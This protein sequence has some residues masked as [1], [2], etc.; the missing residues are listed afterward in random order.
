MCKNDIKWS[1]IAWWFLN[2]VK[3]WI[4]FLKIKSDKIM[5]NTIVC[6]STNGKTLVWMLTDNTPAFIVLWEIKG[7]DSERTELNSA[8]FPWW[9]QAF[10]IKPSPAILFMSFSVAATNLLRKKLSRV[11][12]WNFWLKNCFLICKIL[13]PLKA[14]EQL[15]VMFFFFPGEKNVK[16]CGSGKC[17]AQTK[18]FRCVWSSVV[19]NK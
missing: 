18:T 2:V 6:R 16:K 7:W 4:N 13:T 5:K 14:A 9:G 12:I 17:S 15:L 10:L 11:F 8:S 3:S 1:W 19:D